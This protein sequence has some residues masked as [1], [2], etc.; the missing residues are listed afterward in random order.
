[1]KRSIEPGRLLARGYG[2]T[3]PIMAN[4]TTQ[5]RQKNRRV[6]FHILKRKKP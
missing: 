1:V 5:G 6:E 4:L 3:R 2:P